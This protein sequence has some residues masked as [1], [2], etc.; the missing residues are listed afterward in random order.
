MLTV[1]IMLTSRK[2]KF[3]R[4]YSK[5]SKIYKIYF[6]LFAVYLPMANQWDLPFADSKSKTRQNDMYTPYM[7]KTISILFFPQKK[8]EYQKLVLL[9]FIE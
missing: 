7:S 6:L 3:E 2:M 9:V 8:V 1:N 5:K 4:F